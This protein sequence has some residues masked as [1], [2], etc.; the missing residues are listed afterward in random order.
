M[1][2]AIVLYFNRAAEKKIRD[3][4]KALA[5]RGI[6]TEVSSSGIRPHITLAIYDELK[7]QPCRD[8]LA[9][10]A[11]RT[12]RLEIRI[13]HMGVFRQPETVLFLAP[14]VTR[15]L[16]DLHASIHESMAAHAG[17]SWEVYQPAKWVP[18]CTLAMN[19]DDGK[20]SQAI[21]CCRSIE[22][23]WQLHATGIGAVEFV[24]V[25][26]LFQFDLKNG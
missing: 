2:Y 7:C 19:L 13:T 1:P 21:T 20:L 15:E 3:V 23:P 16:L 4:W 24:P 22:L 8:E 26:D 9:K 10:F 5:D 12:N 18:H 25:S 11:A 14:T 6:S 17:S